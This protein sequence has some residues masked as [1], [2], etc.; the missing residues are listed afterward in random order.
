MSHT[1]IRPPLGLMPR[2][3]YES[4]YFITITIEQRKRYIKDAINRYNKVNKQIPIEWKD[5][6][7]ELIYSTEPLIYI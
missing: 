2:E 6:L 7:D 3:L 1:D 5:E 4:M